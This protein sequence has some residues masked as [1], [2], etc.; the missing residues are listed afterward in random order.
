MT[1]CIALDPQQDDPIFRLP[2]TGWTPAR[3]FLRAGGEYA[4]VIDI[5]LFVCLETLARSDAQGNQRMITI[6]DLTKVYGSRTVVDRVS[7][8]VNHGEVLGL[9]G[10]N[11]AGKSTVMRIIASAVPPTSGRVRVMSCDTVTESI[12]A[13]RCIGYLP[14]HTPLYPDMKVE[15]LLSFAARIKGGRKNGVKDRVRNAVIEFGLE[16]VRNRS[17]ATLSRGYR[18]R[19]GLAQAMINDPPVLVLDEPTQGLDPEHAYE[20]RQLVKDLSGSRTIVLS[21]HVLSEVSQLCSRVAVLNKGRVIAV[22]STEKLVSLHQNHTRITIRV[23]ERL[24]QALKTIEAVEGVI[25]AS[26]S[27]SQ[28]IKAETVRDRDLRPVLAERIVNSG[29]PLLG[30]AREEMS[31]EEVCM[32]LVTG[33]DATRA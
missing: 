22:D 12:K 32:K 13:R 21:S 28:V 10:P 26:S 9:L 3:A 15:S 4:G 14:E 24:D 27:N 19:V 30:I 29:I 31:L 6:D 11:G 33:E 8:T 5:L 23:G 7:L 18:Q 20:I 25:S 16:E 2:V 1:P 17:I